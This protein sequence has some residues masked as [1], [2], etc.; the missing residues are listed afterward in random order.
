MVTVALVI[1]YFFA[2]YFFHKIGRLTIL[3]WE[4]QP[5]VLVNDLA[6]DESDNDLRLLALAE[7]KRI[8]ARKPDP[9]ASE[10]V[11]NWRQKISNP[12][13]TQPWHLFIRQIFSVAFSE[14]EIQ[15][16]GWRDRFSAWVGQI[17]VSKQSAT[18]ATPLLIF[19]YE[20]EPSSD[21]L[22]SRIE[23]YIAEGASIED[24]KIY[25]IYYG[26]KNRIG[27]NTS[28]SQH[29]VVVMS[30]NQLLKKGLKLNNYV[31]DLLQRFS[32]DKL[33][34]TNA[35][36][37]DTFV[38]PHVQCRG[39]PARSPISKVISEW[40]EDSSR[41]QLA[42]TAEYGRGKSTAMLKFCA[43]WAIGYGQSGADEKRIPLLIELRGQ[44]PG[45]SDPLTFISAWAARYALNPKQILNLIEAGEA[46]LIFEGFDEL[47][48]AGRAYDRHE[49]FNALWRMA[50]PGTKVIFTGRPNFF[51]D[52]D[53]KN[54]TLRTAEA[55]AYAY[56]QL[57]ELS[58]LTIDEV[59]KVSAGFGIE[60]GFRI[61]E[62]ARTNSSFFD[63]VSRPS[64][65]P[66]VATIWGKIEEV[67]RKGHDFTSAI[68]LE[69]YIRATYGRKEEELRQDQFTR[70]TPDGSS[71]LILPREVREL[72]T[73]AVV[74]R[75][76]VT[77]ARNTI[78]RETFN[79]IIRNTY[80]GV[81]QITQAQ[82]VDREVSQS[83]RAFEERF[84]DES[85][86][87]R[88][89]RVCSEIASASLF[90]PD[91]AGGQ[92]NLRFPHKQFYEVAWR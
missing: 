80:D 90:V 53:E 72:L 16:N 49:H 63:I 91:P 33:G 40:L 45:E 50:Y 59:R 14:A 32:K 6:K 68:L 39:D 56:T 22:N 26:H 70:K 15:D 86:A 21:E 81:L 69:H 12:P 25:A 31:R 61:A 20:N 4:A 51:I 18:A 9:L 34:G 1:V 79:E 13:D 23:A 8:L 10:V 17:Y 37:R 66:V 7:L 54:L 64:M 36:L 84:K 85:R 67:R 89:E 82:G 11:V 76:A 65:L 83:M 35:T 52:D 24:T 5:T 44:N 55:G 58:P 47:R 75:M 62:A 71:Y 2:V 88:M 60:L 3:R 30:Q 87:D 42:I 27:S 74:W 43:D 77:G 92:N 38:E 29:S 73:T 41:R 78:R 46:I 48:H 28:S 57:W 19:L